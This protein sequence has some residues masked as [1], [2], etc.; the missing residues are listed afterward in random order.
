MSCWTD[1][2]MKRLC[3]GAKHYSTGENEVVLHEGENAGS[4]IWVLLRGRVQVVKRAAG[5]KLCGAR[6]SG[7][8]MLAVLDAPQVVGDF[9]QLTEQPRTANIITVGDCD[10][11]VIPKSLFMN[12]L[13]RLPPRLKQR[14]F[15]TAFARRRAIMWSMFPMEFSDLRKSFL[16]E[17]FTDEQLA[18]MTSR[19]QPRCYRS[20]EYLCHINTQGAEMYFLRRGEVEV[21]VPML[22]EVD[23]DEEKPAPAPAEEPRKK[24]RSKSLLHRGGSFSGERQMQ[25]R[26]VARPKAG[27]CF[28]EFS[29]V[30]GE[31]RSASIRALTHCDVWVLLFSNLEMCF[32]DPDLR[33]KVRAAA[34][35][36]RLKWLLAQE[37]KTLTFIRDDG[38]D[39]EGKDALLRCIKACPVL[40][41]VCTP[42]TF[43]DIRRALEPKCY[44]QRDHITSSSDICDRLLVMTRGRAVVQQNRHERKQFLHT[45][46]FVGFTCLAEHRWL[47]AVVAQEACD[48]WELPRTKLAKILKQ[49]GVLQKT[50]ALIKALLQSDP[51]HAPCDTTQATP[52]LFPTIA[53]ADP[54]SPPKVLGFVAGSSDRGLVADETQRTATQVDVPE[55]SGDPRLRSARQLEQREEGSPSRMKRLSTLH[56]GAVSTEVLQRELQKL[57]AESPSGSKRAN[58]FDDDADD[59]SSDISQLSPLRSAGSQRGS[60]MFG[61]DALG[62]SRRRSHSPFAASGRRGTLQPLTGDRGLQLR[63][64]C[65][66]I[67]FY[68]GGEWE[69]FPATNML[70]PSRDLFHCSAP[71]SGVNT[72]LILKTATPV[73]LSRVEVLGARGCS[74]C[75]RCGLVWAARSV[76]DLTVQDMRPYNGCTLEDW[77]SV[78]AKTPPAGFF[79]VSSPEATGAVDLVPGHYGAI[80]IKFLS[81]WGD[82]SNVDVGA[83]RIL[84]DPAGVSV[85][86]PGG[87]RSPGSMRV[88]RR[89]NSFR[90][91][92][93]SR[94]KSGLSPAASTSPQNRRPSSASP[95]GSPAAARRRQ[96][97]LRF[98]QA[99]EAG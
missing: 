34:T 19:L 3:D 46:E 77:Q 75:V 62:G 65:F 84:E 40:M 5:T 1:D 4:G 76:S 92:S 23:K 99:Q 49:H 79:N 80:A 53:D 90:P 98:A 33:A 72:D 61:G 94:R 81:T 39:P 12:E 25:L 66:T 30:F 24:S 50:L 86:S 60:V 89:T 8:T 35:R 56:E 2:G 54:M 15:D 44:S 20:G 58:I 67:H 68:S 28:G 18:A 16:F 57:S 97:G 69:G 36:Q 91:G 78:H 95:P 63:N 48:V 7:N 45:G 73:P 38:S 83:I 32:T 87:M 47:H 14:V 21:L 52:R 51:L 88:D 43:A 11:A 22:Q 27:A 37:N 74:A 13:E 70:R 93:P 82:D 41:E 85:G 59:A 42:K 26:G 64:D 17:L 9:T 31:K 96:S 10:W 6:H 29:L 55:T 71:G